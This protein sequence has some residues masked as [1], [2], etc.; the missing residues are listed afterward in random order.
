[1]IR[2]PWMV[3]CPACGVDVGWPCRDVATGRDPDLLA[4]HPLRR[5]RLVST[6]PI[7]ALIAG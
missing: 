4:P 6:P 3:R 2:E 5:R 7:A 1:M